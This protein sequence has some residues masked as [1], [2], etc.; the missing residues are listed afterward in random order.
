MD[1]SIITC[2][3]GTAVRLPEDR[4][5]RQFRCPKCK[6][7]IALTVDARVLKSRTLQGS[8]QGAA[9]AICQTAIAGDEAY[10]TCPK[11]EQVYHRE[12]WSEIGG[13]GTYGCEQAPP[14]NKSE[15]TTQA[16]LTA[17]GDTKNCPACGEQIKSI[18]LKCRYCGQQFSSVDPMTIGDLKRQ[19]Y[20]SD[21]LDTFRKWLVGFFV[22]AIPGCLAPIVAI[23]AA[24]YIFSQKKQFDRV[25]PAHKVMGYA[26]IGL[27][28]LYTLLA[29]LFLIFGE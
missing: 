10:V 3:C 13:C 22:V 23:V 4:A 8:E 1:S 27:S 12:C 21:Q 24:I 6:S 5:N 20:R 19:A 18:A 17:W 15:T 26:A 11:C 16:P 25:G 28:V 9:C 2:D 29:V 7:G 14:V